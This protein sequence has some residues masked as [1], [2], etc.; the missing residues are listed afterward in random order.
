MRITELIKKKTLN[1]FGEKP[2]TVA[3]LGDSVTHGC[4]EVYR[5]GEEG[6]ET[7]FEINRSFSTRFKEIMN[8]IYPATQINVINSGISGDTTEGALKR[9]E[10]DIISYNPDLVVVSLGL[11]DCRR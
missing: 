4:F 3:F 2:V 11:N 8:T 10:R 7:V 5:A 9:V 1:R 6:I